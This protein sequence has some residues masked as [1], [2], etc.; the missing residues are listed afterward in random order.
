[1]F[2]VND[3]KSIF[4]TR[5]D[6]V[7]FS[8]SADDNGTPFVFKAGD[9]VRI[10]VFGKKDAENVVL[11]KDFGVS[12]DATSVEIFLSGKDTK[13][14]ETISKPKD[15][16]YEVEVNP[17]DHPQTIIG[18]DEDGAKLFRL[19]PEG[20]DIEYPETD[21]EDIPVVDAE[22][23]MTSHRP[24]ENQAVA[25]AFKGLEEGYENVYAIVAELQVTPD[26]FGGIGDGV[27]DDT[28]ALQS[29]IDSGK[30]V[31]NLMGKTYRIS[32]PIRMADGQVIQNGVIDGMGACARGIECTSLIGEAHKKVSII[33][34]TVR[35]FTEYGIY[36]KRCS[37]SLVANCV[38]EN[39]VNN[40][41]G[42]I[43]KGIC[44]EFCR[45][46][47]VTD[48]VVHNVVSPNDA[49]GIHFMHQD[50]TEDEVF[51]GNVVRNCVTYDCGKRHYKVQQF[52][53]TM[54]GC[55]MLNGELGINPSSSIVSVYDSYFTMKDCFLDADST[56]PVIIGAANDENDHDYRYI[57]IT[58]NRI[59]H[60]G[61]AYQGAIFLSNAS[62]CSYRDI[63]VSDNFFLITNNTEYAL[64]IRKDFTHIIFNNNI[65]NGGNSAVCVRDTANGGTLTCNSNQFDGDFAIVYLTNATVDILSAIGNLVKLNSGD[66]TVYLAGSNINAGRVENTR[67]D[68]VHD[69]PFKN[70]STASRPTV[71][72]YNGY[73]YFD[74][75]LQKP[76]YYY[77]G[78]WKDA[79]GASV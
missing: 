48:C 7:F 36:L 26:V 42:A 57:T 49:D 1:M 53:V 9:V 61:T 43:V 22:L 41:S 74:Q 72:L 2:V 46:S 32:S 70:G 27:A 35:N 14:G 56:N 12:D 55:R 78:A 71:M 50:T 15:Y 31:I 28:E 4:A 76:V 33:N 23:D 19:F 38:V 3:D 40:T 63:I 67:E 64:Y 77:N 17:D 30:K 79:A 8:V 51:S 60:R 6:V 34:V 37:H 58:Q 65:V 54:D 68:G 52:G 62:G 5:G 25:R 24:I 47:V 75:T 11:Q 18:Y 66:R 39:I 21:P 73:Q 29:A 44:L 20:E 59:I 69:M 13:I 16:W 10:K 45:D